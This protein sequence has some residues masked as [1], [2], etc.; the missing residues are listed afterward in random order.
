[1]HYYEL[2]WT[3][4]YQSIFDILVKYYVS[5]PSILD[6]KT[7]RLPIIFDKP[8]NIFGKMLTRLSYKITKS[9]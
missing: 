9:S 2:E 5:M 8:R 1:M 4:D 7:P 6:D 3:K